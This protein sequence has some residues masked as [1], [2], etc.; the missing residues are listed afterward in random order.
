MS[1]IRQ[2]LTALR[3][4]LTPT[5]LLGRIDTAYCLQ[6]VDAIEEVLPDTVAQAERIVRD[7]DGILARATEQARAYLQSAERDAHRMTSDSAILARADEEASRITEQARIKAQTVM[8]EHRAVA[9]D[10]VDSL[11]RYLTAVTERAKDYRKEL[12]AT[13]KSGRR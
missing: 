6:L 10:L 2:Y 4:A 9:C 12:A 3:D 8:D 7:R 13:H 11:V 5:G 1:K